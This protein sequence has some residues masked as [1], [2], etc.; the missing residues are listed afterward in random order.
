MRITLS[1][2][3]SLLLLTSYAQPWFE[4]GKNEDGTL[5]FFKVQ[6]SAEAYFGEGEKERGKGWKPYKRW[7]E[8][9]RHRVNEDGSFPN[10]G[11]TLDNYNR[12]LRENPNVK[13]TTTGD[14]TSL[15]PSTTVGGYNGIGRINCIAFHPTNTNIM[16][17]G[18]PGGGL[19][20]STNNGDTW[21]TVFDQ[22]SVL[23][24]SSIVI[25]PN[26]PDI[27]YIATGDGDA[28][29]TYSTGVLK[30]IDGG[31]TW[32][33]TGLN[34]TVSQGRVIR[35]I[36]MDPD[37]ENMLLAATSNGLYRTINA[38][39]NWTQLLTGNFF[40][41]KAHPTASS[42]TFY[43]CT[44]SVIHTSTNNG[45]NFS[46]VQTISGSNRIALAVSPANASYVYALCSSSSNSGFLGIYRST[47]SGGTS[48]FSLRANS[49]NLLGWNANGSDSGG[50]GWYDLA[51]TVDPVNAEILYVGGVN[52]W[53]STNG[54]T[55]WSLRSH[56]CCPP[57]GIQTTHADKH[58][59]EWQN[60]T[61]LWEGNDGG[62]Y[63]STNGGVNWTD[64]SNGLIISQ[65]YRMDV[66]QQDSKII[67]GLQDNGTKLRTTSGSFVDR[68]G[69]DGMDCAIRPD[70]ASVLY[71]CYQFGNFS[72]S[73]NGGSSF[74]NITGS[75]E[76]GAWVTP[77]VIDPTNTQ[78][79]YLATYRVWRST[80]QGTNWTAISGTLAGSTNNKMDYLHVAPSNSN[81]IY[82]GRGNSLYRTTNGGTN[83]STM[84]VPGN[85]VRELAIHPTDPN[86]IWAVR[87][88]YSN[89][90]KVHKS[91]DGGATW[92]NISDNLPNLPANCII[93]Q[94]G[95]NDG[96]Y[97]GMDV[98]IYY[99]DNTM[100]NWVLFNAGLPNVEIFDLKI[101]YNT[102]ELY[103]GTYGRGFWVSPLYEVGGCPSAVNL[104][105]SSKGV[106]FITLNWTAP[107]PPPSDGYEVLIST[108]NNTPNT[109]GISVSGTEF[110]FTGL[111]SNTDYYCFIRSR[112]GTD[113]SAWS[114]SGPHKTHLTC[115]DTSYDSGG[116]ASNYTDNEDVT[117]IICPSTTNQVVALNFTSFDVESN[118]DALY[119]Y[120]GNTINDPLFSSGNPA[121]NG[122]FP[123]GGYWGTNLPGSF[124]STHA[125]GCITL[126]FRSDES[127]T[128]AGWAAN[129]DCINLCSSV[130]TSTQ[131]S[132]PGSLRDLLACSTSGSV[133]TFDPSISNDTIKLSS[134]III[135]KNLEINGQ[136]LNISIQSEHPSQLFTI[137]TGSSLALSYLK[138]LA[139][140]GINDVRGIVNNGTLSV[141]DL[142]I[143]DPLS[144]STSGQT[145]DSMGNTEL[146]GKFL[147]KEN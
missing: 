10:A 98:G 128:G 83:W 137:Q 33:T 100:N 76:E 113:F 4:E 68:I 78:T 74:Q 90:N 92:T 5:N 132:G 114:V 13:R 123:A 7:E 75:V 140:T 46:S 135:D 54:G 67:G 77:F 27:M 141:T 69:G 41:V 62:V 112:C 143:I 115:G 65:L 142:E 3:F 24:V 2:F 56:W 96:I 93:Y 38:G 108:Q 147:I 43:A 35:R 82:V 30:S 40:D 119:I 21:T 47:N 122:G 31:I 12:F 64:K 39:N 55:N 138:L 86:T 6:S 95:S 17:V 49:P 8:Y 60:N 106:D 37:D 16:W 116:S 26:N 79:I 103:A 45:A 107:S 109:S 88:N 117:W 144:N 120:D 32:Q 11:V 130:I 134:P 104:Q 121:T 124:T 71:G 9:W 145:I 14:W 48:S 133:L 129:I 29:D 66:S 89:G 59:F 80:N 42:N 23:G 85:N 105:V 72:R 18:S 73:T 125:S 118:W 61:T 53:K 58:C 22:N 97:V 87:S 44:G 136:G 1:L 15:G 127:V 91:T 20:Q 51:L 34:W 63:R 25:N 52:S 94:S 131:N 146:R 102:N 84:T 126:R 19:W 81:I 70:N 36:I 111:N 28:A 99:R 139:G 110:Q 101:K 50:Q 57:S